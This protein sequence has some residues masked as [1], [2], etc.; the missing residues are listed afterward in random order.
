LGDCIIKI[1]KTC[2]TFP[3]VFVIFIMQAKK[4]NNANNEPIFSKK[5]KTFIEEMHENE[6]ICLMAKCKINQT[7]RK[8]WSLPSASTIGC[9]SLLPHKVG[10]SEIDQ[11]EREEQIY[12]NS[13][14]EGSNHTIA[15]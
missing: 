13:G 5:K 1:T 3:L 9:T 6:S 10:N 12:Q 11:L 14:V 2:L 7:H 4:S 15:Y 8:V